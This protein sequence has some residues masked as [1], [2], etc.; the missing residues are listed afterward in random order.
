MFHAFVKFI[1]KPVRFWQAVQYTS[2]NGLFKVY[3]N[4]NVSRLRSVRITASLTR[5]VRIISVAMDVYTSVNIQNLS[6]EHRRL[7]LSY[8]LWM[9]R[10]LYAPKLWSTKGCSIGIFVLD[11]GSKDVLSAMLSCLVKRAALQNFWVEPACE[12]TPPGRGPK[13]KMFCFCRISAPVAGKMW[14]VWLSQCSV[15]HVADLYKFG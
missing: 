2:V 4:R 1:E 7:L 12:A 10:P 15:R 13:P 14:M 5:W 11:Y 3:I 9:Y 8:Q 6:S